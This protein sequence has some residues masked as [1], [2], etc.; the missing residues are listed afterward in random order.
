MKESQLQHA[1]VQA[2]QLHGVFFFSVPNE[3]AGN[4]ARRAQHLKAM[5]LRSGV[6]DLVVVLPNQVLFMEVKTD[7][8]KQSDAQK[9]FESTVT[10]LGHRYVVVR[11][12][13]EAIGC[14]VD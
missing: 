9:R 11:S 7:T 6:S 4:N 3:G 10:E 1:I 2:L 5:G 12:V 8:G 14:I 13:D